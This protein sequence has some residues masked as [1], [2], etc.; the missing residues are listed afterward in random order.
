MSLFSELSAGSA[1]TTSQGSAPDARP[2][3]D[4]ALYLLEA[5][6]PFFH[7][8]RDSVLL[9][10]EPVGGVGSGGWGAAGGSAGGATG[11]S[12]TARGV[13]SPGAGVTAGGGQ[14]G[15]RRNN[16]PRRAELVDP[17]SRRQGVG[18][19]PGGAGA[20]VSG[21]EA[22][23]SDA[24]P[25]PTNA[26]P[27]SFHPRAAGTY[28]CRLLVKRRTRQLVDVRCID[29]VAVVD[30]PRNATALLFRVPAGQR[31]TQEVKGPR[32]SFQLRPPR[33]PF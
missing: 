20:S 5:D 14:G 9:L 31:V 30:V 25:P 27:V 12:A 16:A 15:G 11:R 8:A 33:P 21:V 24:V 32:I 23:G 19:E 28:P 26:V 4:S 17:G 29:V 13:G 18:A 7:L 6:S 10:S 1:A 2:A 3:G 22:G